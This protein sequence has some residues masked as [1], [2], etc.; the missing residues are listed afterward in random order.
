MNAARPL[1]PPSCQEPRPGAP[2]AC[3]PGV[4]AR[5]ALTAFLGSLAAMLLLQFLQSSVADPLERLLLMAPL[6]ASA[7]LVFGAPQNAFSQPRNLVGGHVL[8]ALVGVSCRLALPGAAWL[9]M[10][11][12]VAGAIALMRLTRTLHPPGGATAFLGVAGGP[13]IAAQGYGFVL[14]PA[15]SGSL[16][17]FC[18]AWAFHSLNRGRRYPQYWW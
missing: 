9:A 2:D 3:P 13:D 10:P 1:Q 15:L 5:E 16:A 11:L 8:S 7:A 6:G 17:L 12:A 18:A 14:S 4:L